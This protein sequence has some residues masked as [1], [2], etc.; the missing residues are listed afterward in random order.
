MLKYRWWYFLNKMRMI[1]ANVKYKK[2]KK[3]GEKIEIR[4]ISESFPEPPLMEKEN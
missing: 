2:L 3:S 1:K 4:I